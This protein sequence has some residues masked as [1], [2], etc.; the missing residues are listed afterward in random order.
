MRL[1]HTSDWHVGK[2]IR[3]HSR[4][5]EHEAVLDEIV[6]IAEEQTV[7]VVLVAGDIFETASPPPEAEDLVYRTLLALAL[8]SAHVAVALG[9][10]DEGHRSDCGVNIAK[11]HPHGDDVVGI[12]RPV[13]L[14]LMPWCST[15]TR[16]LEQGL[17]VIE[18]HAID[19]QKSCC[20]LSESG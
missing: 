12:E 15:A 13:V 19:A 1:L 20:Y 11:R 18:P 3:G 6:R 2:K 9:A 10:V 14:V 5:D 7:D 16:L 8:T 4:H 17:I